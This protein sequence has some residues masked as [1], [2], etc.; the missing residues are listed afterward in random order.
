M[1]TKT[2]PAYDV[3]TCD[4]CGVVM[5]PENARLKVV[6]KIKTDPKDW[7]EGALYPSRQLDLCNSCYFKIDSA[8]D[9]IIEAAKEMQ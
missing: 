9:A 1:T 7:D 4:C 2:V 6:L 3:T 8:V 5:T